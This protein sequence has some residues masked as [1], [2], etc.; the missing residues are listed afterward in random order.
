MKKIQFILAAAA[1]TLA[2]CANDDYVGSN[3]EGVT[4]K[5]DMIAFSAGSN[6]VTRADLS[7]NEAAAKLANKFFTD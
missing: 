2:S 1:I 6:A 4:G 3:P 7:G 5:A